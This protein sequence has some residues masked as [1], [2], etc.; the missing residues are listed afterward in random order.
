MQYIIFDT[1]RSPLTFDEHLSAERIKIA[2]GSEFRVRGWN[3]RARR[4]AVMGV[5]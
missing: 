2:R 1:N 5:R 4:M 3:R